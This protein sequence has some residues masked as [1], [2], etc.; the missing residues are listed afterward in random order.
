MS[1]GISVWMSKWVGDLMSGWMSE[2]IIGWVSVPHKYKATISS[3]FKW[4]DD[5]ILYLYSDNKLLFE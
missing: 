3:F 2:W 4:K 1:E 5:K